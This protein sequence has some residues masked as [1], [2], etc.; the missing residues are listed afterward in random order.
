MS[1]KNVSFEKVGECLYCNPSSGSYYAVL[2][3]KGKQFKSSLRTKDLAEAR[4]KLRD[5]RNE[6]EVAAPGAN[7]V[8]MKQ[9][10]EKYLETVKDQADSTRV[11]KEIMLKKAQERRRD[12]PVRNLKKSDILQAIHKGVR[13]SGHELIALTFKNTSRPVPI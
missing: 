9:M 13:I 12:L 2:K 10:C 1:T 4:R 8:T 3:V 7:K 11:N 5:K 6:I